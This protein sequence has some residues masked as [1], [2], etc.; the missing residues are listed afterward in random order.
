[1]GIL[2]TRRHF[3]YFAYDQVMDVLNRVVDADLHIRHMESY[4][5]YTLF[6]EASVGTLETESSIH[7]DY[8][9]IISS[10]CR[11]HGRWGLPWQ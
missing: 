1:M 8:L 4:L 10:P 5:I 3:S 6:T 9:T 7:D 2:Y 11:Y